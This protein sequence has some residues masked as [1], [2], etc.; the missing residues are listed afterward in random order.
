MSVVR[1]LWQCAWGLEVLGKVIK[2]W[3]RVGLL[4]I[5]TLIV[6]K[7]KVKVIIA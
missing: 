3:G 7:V 4:V 6:I 2:R 5:E 1:V